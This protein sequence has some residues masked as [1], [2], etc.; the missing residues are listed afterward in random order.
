MT[1]AQPTARPPLGSRRPLLLV[2]IVAAGVVL[3]SGAQGASVPR[4]EGRYRTLTEIVTVR[5]YPGVVPGEISLKNW[6]YLR[7]CSTAGCITT[8]RRPSI[9]A[10]KKTFVY[11]LRAVSPTKYSGRLSVPD[12]CTIRYANGQVAVFA[13]SVADRETVT[14]RV[15]HASN[16]RVTAYKGNLIIRSVPLAIARAHGCIQTGYQR[17]DFKS[18]A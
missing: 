14:I 6:T 16:G 4:L 18:P 9:L 12:S 17:I 8:L 10:R 2:A 15:T 3:A 5:R 11:K 13:N 1:P 7:H